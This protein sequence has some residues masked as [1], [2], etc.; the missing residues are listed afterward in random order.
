VPGHALGRAVG[1]VTERLYDLEHALPGRRADPILLVNY[2][3]DRSG[4]D[5]GLTRYIV[6]SGG[7]RT[8]ESGRPVAS[9]GR[10]PEQPAS[11]IVRQPPRVADL[12]GYIPDVIAYIKVPGGARQSWSG[13]QRSTVHAPGSAA[14]S[15]AYDVSL[16]RRCRSSWAASS[17]SLC[18]HSAARYMQAMI[19]MRWTRL[20]SP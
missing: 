16:S 14:C 15:T 7:R 18:R 3:R 17:T 6:E 10:P 20:K 9:R 1:Y 4:G 11:W 2:P 12:S 8:A 13:P 19:P 5:S